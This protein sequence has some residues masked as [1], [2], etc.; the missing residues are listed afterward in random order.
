V[1]PTFENT[2]RRVDTV[3][4]WMTDA[5]ARRLWERAAEVDDGGVIVEI[6]SFHGRSTIVLAS[7]SGAGV[8]VF[9]IDPH[10]GGDRGPR[11]VTPDQTRGDTDH[12][13]FMANIEAAGVA[14]RVTHVRKPS[15]DAF[16]D[17]PPSIDLLYI[18]G[19]HRY[20]PALDDIRRWGSRVRDE[21]TML[22]HDSWSSVGVTGA[23]L[24]EMVRSTEWTYRGRAGSLAEYAR[25]APAD[26]RANALAQLREVPW[27]ARNVLIKGLLVARAKPL[28]RLLGHRTGYWPY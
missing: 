21:G 22:I 13:T 14:G 19:A 26:R 15:A 18:D 8:R 27:F 6:G 2:L 25:V 1:P 5:Q 17:A 16:A 4:G 28:T 10:G 11:E 3:D 12:R 20:A 7:A 9:A 24:V 23:L